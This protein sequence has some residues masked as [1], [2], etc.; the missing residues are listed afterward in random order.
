MQ[1]AQASLTTSFQFFT[2]KD[3]QDKFGTKLSKMRLN[4]HDGSLVVWFEDGT[5][6]FLIR[7][8]E[9]TS[10]L[11]NLSEPIYAAFVH[12][13]AD[14]LYVS[15]GNSIYEFRA[16]NTRKSLAWWSKDFIVPKPTN[17]GAMQLIGSGSLTLE[18]YADGTMTHTQAVSLDDRGF[19]IVRLPSGFLARRWSFKFTGSAE[20]SE[21]YL[22][23][24]VT[25]LQNA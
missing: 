1:G 7:F 14:A 6:G 13:L 16:G 17:F 15:N 20:I 24:S 11:T 21:A 22:A 2:R 23:N 10:S 9:E 8:E 3:W 5:P 25:E 12:P 19:A 4:A 18:V